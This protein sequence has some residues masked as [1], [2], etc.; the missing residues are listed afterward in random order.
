MKIQGYRILFRKYALIDIGVLFLILVLPLLLSTDQ[1]TYFLQRGVFLSGLITPVLCHLEIKHSNQLP[2][3]YNLG[4]PLLIVY[5]LLMA[6]K[7]I[8]VFGISAYG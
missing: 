2:F 3:F 7:I 1:G 8:I 5:A 6:L 4:I